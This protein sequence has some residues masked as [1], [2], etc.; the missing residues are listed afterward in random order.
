MVG[1]QE[2]SARGATAAGHRPPA[3]EAYF[4]T[5]HC[6]HPGIPR[7]HATPSE[8]EDAWQEELRLRPDDAETLN[9]VGL[10]IWQQGRI[11]DAYELFVRA[12]QLKPEDEEIL[13]NLG[14]T[15]W[16]QGRVD[17][18]AECYRAAL[19]VQ[20]DS[21]NARMNLGVLASDARRLDEAMEWL[22]SAAQLR[23]DSADVL[24]NL[25]MT[26]ARMDRWQEA[27]EYYEQALRLRPDYAEVHV[28]RAFAWLYHGDYQRGWPE[29]EWRVKRR[30]H[31]G[32]VVHRPRW[33]GEELHGR[34]ILLHYE[35]ALGDTLQFIRF[36]EPVKQRGG[37]VLV[38]CPPTL[39]R[40]VAHCPFVDLAF[41]GTTPGQPDCHVHA[42]LMSL[43]TILGTTL[44]TLPARVP[45]LGVDTLLVHHWRSV[46]ASALVTAG[47]A[48]LSDS[49]RQ[50]GLSAPPLARPFLIGVVWQ[51][52][53][54][55]PGDRWRSFPLTQ[56]APL[57]E[58]P[59]VR[60]V[61]LQVGH[62]REQIAAL[63]GRFPILELPGRRPRDFLDT[64]AIMTQLNLV[65][66]PDSAVAHLAGGLGL[67]TWVALSTQSEWR[68]MAHREDSPWYPTMRLF[69]QKRLGDWDEL[70]RRMAGELRRALT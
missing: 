44:E 38:L 51:G 19:K 37:R 5:A 31:Q 68:W 65:V 50:S 23:P 55:H 18:A 21:F 43:P 69:R 46:L 45:Y 6:Y 56:L 2:R 36:A 3:Q 14:V 58:L 10:E 66:A 33:K 67:P 8:R 34:F 25:G 47:Q 40:L 29:L 39:L 63:G 49:E 53:P 26:L 48:F 16:E 12:N 30:C 11:L 52:S 41:D 17:E 62:G 59:G 61:S 57:A 9:R 1:I 70:F 42:P 22:R 4:T 15:L 54:S 32:F 64:A 13:N 20:P 35:Q 60:L 27:I 24:Q 7:T 28:N